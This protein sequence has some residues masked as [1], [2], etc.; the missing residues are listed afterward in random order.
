M[1]DYDGNSASSSFY[2]GAKTRH[3]K[4]ETALSRVQSS[5]ITYYKLSLYDSLGVRHYWVDSAAVTTNAPALGA[6]TYDYATFVIEQI[7]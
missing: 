2:N 1:T 3:I 4:Y 7:F 5:T 6:G